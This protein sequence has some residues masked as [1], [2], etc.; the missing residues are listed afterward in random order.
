MPVEVAGEVLLLAALEAMAV[1]LQVSLLELVM[2]VRHSLA[3]AVAEYTE[4]VS[5]QQFLVAQA[6]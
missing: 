6:S 4:Q 3:V 2:L 5:P 1:A